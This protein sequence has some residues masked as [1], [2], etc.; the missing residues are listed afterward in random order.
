M[1]DA[2]DR[3][4]FAAFMLRLR[5]K[6]AV[7]QGSHRRLRGD[8]ARAPSWPCT[9]TTSPGRTACC[10][11]NAARRSKA[12]TCRRMSLRRSS[13]EPGHRVL[14]VGTGSGYTAAVISRLAGRVTTLDRYKTLVD[15]AGSGSSCSAS[16]M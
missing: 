14:E 12:P 8:A 1:S 10:R 13:F 5:G 7:P 4:G 16:R 9:F 11:S 15:L 2:S 3:E 6:G